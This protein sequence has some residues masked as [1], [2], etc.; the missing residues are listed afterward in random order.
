[1]SQTKIRHINADTLHGRSKYAVGARLMLAREALG[2]SQTEF[3]ETI[4]A[5]KNSYNSYEVG[6]AFPPVATAIAIK[7]VYNIPLDWVYRG[8]ILGMPKPLLGAI[9]KLHELRCGPKSKRKAAP[10]AA[11]KLKVV[12]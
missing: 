11:P 5:H 3:A 8:D 7:D 1:M 2:M 6:K 9:E 4:D 12:E 10:K